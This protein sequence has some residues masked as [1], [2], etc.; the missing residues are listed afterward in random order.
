MLLPI[1]SGR[2]LRLGGFFIARKNF[3]KTV[4]KNFFEILDTVS[5]QW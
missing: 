4:T 5:E 2:L 3:H 1:Q